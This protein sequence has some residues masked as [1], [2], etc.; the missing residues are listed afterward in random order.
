MVPSVVLIRNAERSQRRNRKE[1][2]EGLFRRRRMI[3]FYSL[4]QCEIIILMVY[5]GVKSEMIAAQSN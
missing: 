4:F 1:L 3:Y 2:N 5:R